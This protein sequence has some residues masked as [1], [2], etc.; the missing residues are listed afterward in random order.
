MS[1]AKAKGTRAET[2]V[3]NYLKDHGIS[4]RRKALAGSADE[5]DVEVGF[6]LS[7]R[8]LTLEVKAGKQTAN[9][10]RTQLE[11]WIRQASEEG[12]RAGTES[13]LVVVRY[14]RKLC[15]ADVWLVYGSVRE[16]M[17]LDEF[18]EHLKVI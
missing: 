3:V 17:Y 14:K 16:H 2:A 10:N 1:K 11:D 13:A 9:P 12:A 8:S 5:G 7:K 4:A 15:D 6:A 18:A